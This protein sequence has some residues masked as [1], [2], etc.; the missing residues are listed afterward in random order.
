M[1]LA[2]N[3]PFPLFARPAQKILKWIQ[4][5]TALA[6]ALEI[7][8]GDDPQISEWVPSGLKHIFDHFCSPGFKIDEYLRCNEPKRELLASAIR[9]VIPDIWL[10]GTALHQIDLQVSPLEV[11]LKTYRPA[12]DSYVT[13][14]G[15]TFI[16]GFK[17][18]EEPQAFEELLCPFTNFVGINLMEVADSSNLRDPQTFWQRYLILANDEVRLRHHHENPNNCVYDV[19]LLNDAASLGLKAD[20]A[21]LLGVAFESDDSDLDPCDQLLLSFFHEPTLYTDLLT[22][23]SS[24]FQKLVAFHPQIQNSDCSRLSILLH[25]VGILSETSPADYPAE[26]NNP[27]F[28][29]ATCNLQALRVNVRSSKKGIL[30]MLQSNEALSKFVRKQK[31]QRLFRAPLLDRPLFCLIDSNFSGKET[32]RDFIQWFTQL[33]SHELTLFSIQIIIYL[34]TLDESPAE[35]DKQLLALAALMQPWTTVADPSNRLVNML[36]GQVCKAKSLVPFQSVVD[37]AFSSCHLADLRQPL[38]FFRMHEANETISIFAQKAQNVTFASVLWAYRYCHF[39]PAPL[40]SLLLITMPEMKRV[41]RYV[42]LFEFMRKLEP[43]F[44]SRLRPLFIFLNSFTFIEEDDRL[45]LQ[46]LKIANRLWAEAFGNVFPFTRHDF[47]DCETC[48]E[49]LNF[50]RTVIIAFQDFML[51]NFKEVMPS[52]Q[53]SEVPFSHFMPMMSLSKLKFDSFLQLQARV[54]IFAGA[55]AVDDS[56]VRILSQNP[57]RFVALVDRHVEY[58]DRP[59]PEGPIDAFGFRQ[60]DWRFG[61]AR[62]LR[63]I[64]P[65]CIQSGVSHFSHE[66]HRRF[67]FCL[68]LLVAYDTRKVEGMHEFEMFQ[69][70]EGREETRHGGRYRDERMFV[71][72]VSEADMARWQRV[73]PIDFMRNVFRVA[74]PASR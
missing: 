5:H 74:P 23:Q 29:T 44:R 11:L 42:M 10:C 28:A 4:C 68:T 55:K 65:K 34:R 7:L 73:L 41:E 1:E 12:L 59:E 22:H 39:P 63:D 3:V 38:A 66:I 24:S 48:Y 64:F 9:Q 47:P 52:I 32:N 53:I 20:A 58:E 25:I 33:E 35:S 60:S 71:P 62:G 56:L 61:L 8:S 51:A 21:S 46:E 67:A 13:K 17:S 72:E 57:H 2:N 18:N 70:C 26:L 6:E 37:Q 49:Q 31:W 27:Y 19:N 40:L 30:G 16:A 43:V 54:G 36:L 14:G 45:A 50:A 15:R 69:I